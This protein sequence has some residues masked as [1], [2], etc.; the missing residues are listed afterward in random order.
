MIIF[1][2]DDIIVQYEPGN[3]D[4]VLITFMGVGHE[5]EARESFFLKGYCLKHNI[6]CVGFT[7]LKRSWYLSEHTEHAL[8][9][10]LSVTRNYRKAIGIGSSA[11]GFAVIKHAQRLNCEFVFSLAPTFHFEI[12][13][14]V[15]QFGFSPEFVLDYKNVARGRFDHDEKITS[16]VV[17]FFDPA[18]PIDVLY[19]I[20]LKDLLKEE[21][22]REE[23]LLTIPLFYA[24]HVVSHSLRQSTVY[25]DMVEFAF[26]KI[27]FDE[28]K[29]RVSRVR[30]RNSTNI[31]YRICA[32]FR[33]HPLLVYRMLK[34][35]IWKRKEATKYEDILRDD[36]LMGS[37]IFSLYNR[38]YKEEGTDLYWYVFQYC[39]FSKFD[40]TKPIAFKAQT[41]LVVGYHGNLMG[42]SPQEKRLVDYRLNS[43]GE[44][45]LPVQ[46]L[47][48]AY[49]YIPAVRFHDYLF[50]MEIINGDG[51]IALTERPIFDK[52]ARG[53]CVQKLTEST[54]CFKTSYGYLASIPQ[55]DYAMNR[56]MVLGWETFAPV[57]C[58]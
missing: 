36:T 9:A 49:G 8:Q 58:P 23:K 39:W 46:L 43:V 11:G 56:E 24:G 54:V 30:R 2:S 44:M 31:Y 52:T 1:D 6:S 53:L 20:A 33:K 47:L 28:L 35:N 26:G 12:E 51:E 41:I 4:Y 10:C 29:G 17:T 19:H 3:T 18:Y 27:T 45:V 25:T 40:D 42:Y 22:T 38:G 50:G 57:M 37:I 5:E 48:T 14:Y 21:S 34:N 32:G 13:Q 7:S 16:T 55:G 15:E